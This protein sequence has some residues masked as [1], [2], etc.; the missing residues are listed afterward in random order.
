[1]LETLSFLNRLPISGIK[2]QLLHILRNTD[3]ADYYEK[4]PFPLPDLEEY[5]ALLG[6][7]I[8]HMR[9]DIVIHRLTGDGPKK[10]LVATSWTGNKREVLNR[11]QQYLKHADLWQGKDYCP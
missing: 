1:M 7:L 11:I 6:T 8:S 3:L 5:V 10:L 4:H 9:P 2:L